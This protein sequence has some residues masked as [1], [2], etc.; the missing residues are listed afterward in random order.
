M[1][2]K[3]FKLMKDALILFVIT[4][5]SG[6][7][8]G[9]V[10]ELTKVPIA[11]REMET[12]LKAYQIVYNS[13]DHIKADEELIL[14]VEEQGLDKIDKAYTGIYI[15]EVNQ[16]YD[17]N[18]NMIGYIVI[19]TTNN[20]YGGP[21]TLALGYTVD[22]VMMGVEILSMNETADLG[23]KVNDPEFKNQFIDREQQEFRLIKGEVN[24]DDEIAA[25][26]GATMSSDA[27]VDAINGSLAFINEYGAISGGDK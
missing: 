18:N 5:I 13:A 19:T 24:A 14:K 9:F 21:I 27:V 3:Y 10:N 26:S 4:L 17:N 16:A 2:N 12:K 7:S 23:S 1:S 11:A 8:L 20:G 6:L 25:V 22:G 15:N